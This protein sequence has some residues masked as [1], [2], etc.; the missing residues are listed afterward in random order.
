[1][2]TWSWTDY[3]IIACLGID[4]YCQ[5]DNRLAVAPKLFQLFA[6][7]ALWCCP[8]C[9]DAYAM[10]LVVCVECWFPMK[11]QNG[12]WMNEWMNNVDL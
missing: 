8:K 6:F 3:K 11:G 1:M 4:R 9:F 12:V 7:N 10:Q 5:I 2:Y